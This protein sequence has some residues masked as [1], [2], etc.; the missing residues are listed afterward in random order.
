[1]P[2]IESLLRNEDSKSASVLGDGQECPA[3]GVNIA[4]H[5]DVGGDGDGVEWVILSTNIV[6]SGG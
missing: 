4:T 3:L 1:M 2:L 6:G 5:Q